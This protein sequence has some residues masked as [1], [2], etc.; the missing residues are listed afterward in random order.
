M[1]GVF[2][3]TNDVYKQQGE[4]YRMMRAQQRKYNRDRNRHRNGGKDFEY[5]LLPELPDRFGEV[6]MKYKNANEIEVKFMG[7]KDDCDSGLKGVILEDR[8]GI[9]IGDG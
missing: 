6:R 4:Q 2:Y 1:E 8:N 7:G 9:I 3:I 5:V